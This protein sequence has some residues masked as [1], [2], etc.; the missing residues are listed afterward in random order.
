MTPAPTT[1]YAETSGQWI[2]TNWPGTNISLPTIIEYTFDNKNIPQWT[3]EFI[4]ALSLKLASYLV[5]ALTTGD[6][7]ATQ[8]KI[9]QLYAQAIS[10]AQTMAGNNEQRPEEPESE[11]IRARY[12]DWIYNG[13]GNG[14]WV[15]TPAGFMV[16]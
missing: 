9:E 2:Y 7:N 11:F 8:Q 12:G 10:H 3:P 1:P 5:P 15:A 14:N 13:V 6:P 4:E 16:D